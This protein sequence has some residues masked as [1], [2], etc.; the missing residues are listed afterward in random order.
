MTHRKR[1]ENSRGTINLKNLQKDWTEKQHIRQFVS[2]HERSNRRKS[3][4]HSIEISQDWAHQEPE[5][6]RKYEK[7][8]EING[9]K[10]ILT[11]E[12][13]HHVVMIYGTLTL[14]NLKVVMVVDRRKLD[15]ILQEK[16]KGKLENFIDLFDFDPQTTSLYYIT[17]D[18]SIL[19]EFI[20]DICSEFDLTNLKKA[21]AKQHLLVAHLKNKEE[22][23][24]EKS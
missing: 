1:V 20:S 17:A 21:I 23:P 6:I 15:K 2:K 16:C 4:S 10:I 11:I 3:I 22:N 9:T 19:D 8:R 14:G 12:E 13:Y 24:S 5:K 7:E 18:P